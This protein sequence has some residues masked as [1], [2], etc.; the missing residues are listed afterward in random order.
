MSRPRQS[1]QWTNSG[2]KTRERRGTL[3]EGCRCVD[4]TGDRAGSVVWCCAV[5]KGRRR[6][7][8]SR[9]NDAL[10]ATLRA[11]GEQFLRRTGLEDAGRD[12]DKARLGSH[13]EEEESVERER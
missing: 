13:Q 2:C 1:S 9:A 3:S 8:S 12:E 6:P 5:G 11:R 10:S 7:V 4:R